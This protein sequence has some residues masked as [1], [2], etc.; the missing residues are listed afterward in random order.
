MKVKNIQYTSSKKN[1]QCN[2]QIVIFTAQSTKQVPTQFLE[3]W[4]TF[5]QKNNKFK[6]NYQNDVIFRQCF[7]GNKLNESEI[8]N[9]DRANS[10]KSWWISNPEGKFEIGRRRNEW[11]GIE[12]ESNET[13]Y[14]REISDLKTEEEE[15]EI[16]RW[17]IVSHRR[18]SELKRRR[19]ASVTLVSDTTEQK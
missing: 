14:R 13:C 11:I 9:L 2:K 12:C 10:V 16:G 19:R 17:Q 7:L 15:E 4:E 8:A 6:Q 3:K 1:I 5:N 18:K